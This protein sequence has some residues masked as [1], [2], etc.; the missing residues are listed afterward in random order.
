MQQP[1][2]VWGCLVLIAAAAIVASAMSPL[3]AWRQPIYII[4]GFA[5]ILALTILLFQP[6]LMVRQMPGLKITQ[7]RNIHLWLG[8]GLILAVVIHILG[9]WIT[10]P[11]DVVDALLFNSPTPFSVW[12]VVAMWALLL[13]TCVVVLRRRFW[14]GFS[15]RAWQRLHRGLG[16]VIVVCTVVHTVLIDGAMEP[17]TKSLLCL[18]VILAS[19]AARITAGSKPETL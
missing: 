5:G 17:F 15:V 1:W 19:M 16:L 2:F 4:A 14:S 13:S 11:P 9:L 10:S 12:G 8:V 6:L 3:L 18:A 7:R